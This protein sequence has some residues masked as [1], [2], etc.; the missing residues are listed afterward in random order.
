[1]G[2]VCDALMCLF[3]TAWHLHHFIFGIVQIA[4]SSLYPPCLQNK[5]VGVREERNL[6]RMQRSLSVVSMEDEGW[7]SM[8][9]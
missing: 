7:G 1:M 4:S 9:S 8:R 2:Y 5:A 6:S 3:S